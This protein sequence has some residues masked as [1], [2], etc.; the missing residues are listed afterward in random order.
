MNKFFGIAL[1]VVALAV[2]VLPMF[3]DCQ[4]QGKAIALANGKTVPMKCHWTGVG[5]LAVAI[6]AVGVGAMMTF[7]RRKENRRNLAVLG[8]IVGV[9]T[10]LLPTQLI[11][12]C[13]TQMLCNTVMKPSLLAL[14]GVAITVSALAFV[15]AWRQAD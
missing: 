10:M 5:E 9:V 4:S 7:S 11:G 15:S 13:S 3:T 1:V 12:V 2:A 6:P 14:G 8:G